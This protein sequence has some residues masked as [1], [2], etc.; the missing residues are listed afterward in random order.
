MTPIPS[1]ANNDHPTPSLRYFRVLLYALQIHGHVG[2]EPAWLQV[3]VEGHRNA[4]SSHVRGAGW[5]FCSPFTILSASGVL[6]LSR[7]V[8]QM[9]RDGTSDHRLTTLSQAH[10][11]VLQLRGI[12]EITRAL[13]LVPP[14]QHAGDDTYPQ[15]SS[16]SGFVEP[17]NSPRHTAAM[18]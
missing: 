12:T 9:V 15:G 18:G 14:P 11:L 4:V 10:T 1:F 7:Y 16:Q 5:L 6:S 2:G 3:T 17:T 13:G 8:R